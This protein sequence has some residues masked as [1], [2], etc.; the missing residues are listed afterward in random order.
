[1]SM[2][3]TRGPEEQEAGE[4]K[5]KPRKRRLRRFLRRRPV[6]V[7]GALLGVAVVW[8]SFSVGQ[9]VTAPGG[10]SFSSKLAEWA[11]DHQLG[12]LVTLGEWLSYNPPKTG[13]KP[14]F[15]LT[16]PKGESLGAAAKGDH[17][18]KSMLAAD[19]PPPLSSLAGKA[20]PGE[21]QWRVL[22]KVNGQPAILSTFLRQSATYSSYVSAVVSMDPRMVKFQL[23]PG[24]EDPGPGNWGPDG[25][26]WIPPA[27]RT[28]LLATFNSGFKID[29][30]R[31][32]FYLNG[33]SVG[34]LEPGDASFVYYK[35]GTA[36]IGEWGRDLRMTPQVEAVRQNLQLIVDNGQIPDAV[37]QNVEDGWGFTLGGGYFVW[38]SGVGMTKDGRIVFVYGPALN[39]RQLAT[40]LQHAGAVQGM[41]LDINPA[42]TSYEYYQAAKN[43]KSPTAVNLLPDQEGSPQRYEYIWSRDFTAVY[44][45]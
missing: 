4:P 21:G 6:R 31:G 7:A 26:P 14:S 24:S 20:L 12:A 9:A 8:L 10:G 43:P 45:R 1:M 17:R 16:V 29:A 39:V 44:T 28:G 37:D 42:W 5:E 30:S 11:R 3:E 35:D 23:H 18:L 19:I 34:T 25:D 22:E 27:K 36:K 2:Q 13:G 41:Q 38:R 15:N 32:G 40:L 33:T